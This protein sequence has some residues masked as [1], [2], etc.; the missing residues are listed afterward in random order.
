METKFIKWLDSV[1]DPA[2]ND[3]ELAK[4]LKVSRNQVWIWRKGI[5]PRLNTFKNVYFRLGLPNDKDAF[6]KAHNNSFSYQTAS[7]F[8]HF[9]LAACPFA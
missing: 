3:A 4:K 1:K 6:W 9:L 5:M 2:D 8:S 7:V